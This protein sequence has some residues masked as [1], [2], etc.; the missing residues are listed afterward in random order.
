[1]CKVTFIGAGKL[2]EH[3]LKGFLISGGSTQDIVVYGRT[4]KSFDRVKSL[5]VAMTT[6]LASHLDERLLI[7]CVQP[8]HVG[9]LAHD[10]AIAK[11]KFRK[12]AT[13]K[14][15]PEIRVLSL[16]SGQSINQISENFKISPG[17]IVVATMDTNAAIGRTSIP[18]MVHGSRSFYTGDAL[19]F[20]QKLGTCKQVTSY[21]HV[22]KGV[23]V[24]GAGKAL[25]LTVLR[26]LYLQSSCTSPRV[27]IDTLD[28]CFTTHNIPVTGFLGWH[29]DLGNNTDELL[30]KYLHKKT[31]AVQSVFG[32]DKDAFYDT[33]SSFA[34]T[35]AMLKAEPH[36]VE[37]TFALHI[38]NI[39]TEGGCTERGLGLVTHPQHF[40]AEDYTRAMRKQIGKPEDIKENRL[41]EFFSRVH[42]RTA[43]FKDD[44]RASFATVVHNEPD[45]VHLAIAKGEYLFE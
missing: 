41:R 12:G 10:L 3:V 14:R 27:F 4:E 28:E 6:D 43:R 29:L 15:Y 36:L 9:Q 26:L 19:E 38:K 39:A 8:K 20:L 31:E 22:L 11:E 32:K 24:K 16:I 42:H 44:A 2:A 40:A 13:N 5:G 35:I 37:E 7:F 23:T 21:A 45:P 25:D 33:L 30:K 18:Y 34:G 1:M 17:R